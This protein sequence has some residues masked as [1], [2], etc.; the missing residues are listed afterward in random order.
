MKLLYFE[1]PFN[2]TV[3]KWRIHQLWHSRSTFDSI[4]IYNERIRKN[5]NGDLT[6]QLHN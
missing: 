5:E 4:S 3:Q 1:P 2:E 6:F